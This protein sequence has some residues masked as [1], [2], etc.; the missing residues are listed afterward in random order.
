MKKQRFTWK[1]VDERGIIRHGFWVSEDISEVHAHLH[2]KGFF[3]VRIRAVR[4][5]HSIFTPAL[6]S[7]RWSHF[8]RRLGTLLEAGIPLLQALEIMTS[9]EENLTFEQEQWKHV[10]ERVEAG[11]DLSEALAL[12][13]PSPNMFVFSMIK[14]GE[15]TGTLGKVLNEVSDELDQE[16]IYHKKIKSVLA[17]PL[18]LFFAAV[19]VL[20]VLSVWV[21][22]MYEG[23]FT[24]MGVKTPFLTRVI[25]AAGRYIPL[26]VWS[27]FAL[28]IGGLLVMK[29]RVS[30]GWRIG[31]NRLLEL[32][33]LLSK[34]YLLQ[35]LVQFSRILA[36]LIDAGIPL[37][38][39]LRLTSGTL[40]SQEML[41]LTNKLL[42]NVRQGKRMA[43]LL[44]ASRI[45][46]REGAEM[47]SVAEESG[48]LDRIL[49]YVT[50]MFR[51]ELEDQLNQITRLIEPILILALAGLIGLVA[52]GVMLPIID[53]SS[54]LE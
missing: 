25:F 22:P 13:N 35:D 53:L 31:L 32:L 43:P 30:K 24:S 27:S 11:S 42:L 34:I 23:L 39:A 51:R 16:L 8:T 2:A 37:L 52:S 18:L 50:L 15:Y 45:F 4:D 28:F 33:P 41:N 26:L 54:H 36:R 7:I 6:S 49:H 12:L 38:D 1:A 40:R 47:I 5:W 46:P 44:R 29:Y 3:P 48:Q 10:K 21:L 20:F 19:I 17:Y 9:H 14:A